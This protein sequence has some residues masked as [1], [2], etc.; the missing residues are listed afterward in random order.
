[1]MRGAGVV[2]PRL[3][4]VP[5][6]LAQANRVVALWHRHHKPVQGHRFNDLWAQGHGQPASSLPTGA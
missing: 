1:M 4:I 5:V 2:K 3:R 6:E